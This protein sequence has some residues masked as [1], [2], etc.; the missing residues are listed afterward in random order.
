MGEKPSLQ[1]TSYG[2]VIDC[3]FAPTSL[4]IVFISFQDLCHSHCEDAII[5]NKVTAIINCF[6]NSSIPPTVQIDIPQEQAQKIIAHRRDLGP[7]VFREAQVFPCTQWI[8]MGRVD[9]EKAGSWFGGVGLNCV[10]ANMH[11][12]IY[13]ASVSPLIPVQRPPHQH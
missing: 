6:I 4:N 8:C 7:Y 11:Q 3:C 2:L 12:C 13:L 1:P 5:Q 10:T 9:P